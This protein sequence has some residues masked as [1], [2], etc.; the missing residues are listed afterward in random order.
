MGRKTFYRNFEVKEDVIDFLLD[1]LCEE[2]EQEIQGK[3]AD[4]RLAHYFSFSKKHIDLFQ[5]MYQ[6]GLMPTMQSRFARL[7]PVTM[8]LWSEDPVEQAY[9]SRF[10]S[11]GVQAIMQL[12]VERS[13]QEEMEQVV[14]LARRVQEQKPL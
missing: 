9:Y 13:F 6:Q 4:E 10:A 11:A 12:W 3:T 1:G 7:L 2:F 8:P 14:S 5:T